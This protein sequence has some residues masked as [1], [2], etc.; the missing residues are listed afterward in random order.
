MKW[1]E[2]AR[3]KAAEMQ[4]A[5]TAAVLSVRAAGVDNDEDSVEER[6]VREEGLVSDDVSEG[7]RTIRIAAAETVAPAD[8]LTEDEAAT[9][10]WLGEQGLPE[11][12]DAEDDD[13]GDVVAAF[14]RGTAGSEDT[15]D[16][17]LV[18]RSSTRSSSLLPLYL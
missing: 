8:V 6:A 14:M 1:L 4:A 3:R 18:Y 12:D 11:E 7:E 10:A 2:V 13:D 9:L 5:T 17:N 16:T 15:S